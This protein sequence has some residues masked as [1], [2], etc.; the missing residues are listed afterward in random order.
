MTLHELHPE[1]ATFDD[2]WAEMPKQ[3]HQLEARCVWQLVIRPNG[4]TTKIKIGNAG[5]KATVTLQA[6]PEQLVVAATKYRGSLP[7]EADY[8]IK[9]EQYLPRPGVWLSEGMFTQWIE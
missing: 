1:P 5:S 3:V 2:W 8:T 6:T 9:D 4:W 7:R